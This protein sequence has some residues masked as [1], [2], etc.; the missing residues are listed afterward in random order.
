MYSLLII[1]N[2]GGGSTIQ[3]PISDLLILL[4]EPRLRGSA[5]HLNKSVQ[6]LCKDQMTNSSSTRTVR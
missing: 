2:K 5:A 6:H 4:V 3:A 1:D